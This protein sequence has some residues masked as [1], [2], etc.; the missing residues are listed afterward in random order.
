MPGNGHLIVE[1]TR[2]QPNIVLVLSDQQRWDSL[3]CYGNSFVHSPNT[4]QM[5]RQG[6]AFSHCF[7]P[8]PLCTP[9]RATMWTG[10]Y[11]HAHKV[12]GNVYGAHDALL[13]VSQD[14]IVQYGVEDALHSVAHDP[15]NLFGLLKKSGY[16]TAYFGKWHLGT[17]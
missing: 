13:S 11:T 5:A 2:M 17:K 4:D 6:T 1:W 12:V 14:T 7:T 15:I 9:A 8:W 10:L 16:V 3:G